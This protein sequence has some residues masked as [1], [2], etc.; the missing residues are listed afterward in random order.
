MPGG[1]PLTLPFMGLSNGYNPIMPPYPPFASPP[2]SSV[3][4]VNAQLVDVCRDHDNGGCS[5]GEL[6]RFAHPGK[7]DG[8]VT[9]IPVRLPTCLST[10]HKLKVPGSLL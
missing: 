4:I 3:P 1:F 9:S 6:C 5:R 2:P 10:C 7:L 8:K